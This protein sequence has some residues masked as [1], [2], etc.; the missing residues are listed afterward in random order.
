MSKHVVNVN[1]E[2]Y[3]IPD[4]DIWRKPG[5]QKE[6]ITHDGV[7][8]LMVR[9]GITVERTEPVV[10]PLAEG[11]VRIAFLAV[12]TNAEG[13]RAFAVGEADPNN[14]APNTVA[15]RFPTI[16]AHKRAID[17]LVL[18]LLGLFDLY[19]DVEFAEPPER[20]EAPS[21]SNGDAKGTQTSDGPS[22]SRTADVSGSPG[23]GGNGDL[24]P[25]D[26]QLAYLLHLGQKHNLSEAEID[27]MLKVVTTRVVASRL[28]A[29]MRASAA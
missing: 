10:M 29:N 16:M 20:A 26:R 8:K 13:R 27:Q 12:G 17:R 14:L 18:D 5:C 22:P 4:S 21:P 2:K 1:G 15:A 11:T 6:I 23:N 19:S 3:T 28:I 7:R 25:T 9:A 24:P